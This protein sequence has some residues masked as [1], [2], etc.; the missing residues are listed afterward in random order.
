MRG[1]FAKDSATPGARAAK[2]AT[3][4]HTVG[5][6]WRADRPAERYRLDPDLDEGVDELALADPALTAPQSVS[7]QSLSAQTLPSGEPSLS[8]ADICEPTRAAWRAEIADIGGRSPLLHFEDSPYTRID[9]TSTHPGGLAKFIAGRRTRLSS[10]IREPFA[11]RTAA[12]AADAISA[13]GVELA[14]A[15]GIDSVKLGI[16]LAEWSVEGERFRAPVLLRPVRL[17]R[18]GSDFEIALRGRSVLNRAFADELATRF[19]VVLDPEAFAALASADGAFTPNAIIDR[20]RGLTSHLEDFTVTPRLLVS[21]FADVARPML[22]DARTLAHPVLDALAGN[23]AAVETVRES[24]PTVE[25]VPAD[26]RAP[27]IDRLVLDADAEQDQV[28]ARIAAGAS[29]V[30]KTL[31]GTGGTQTIVN[32]I[33]ALVADD[34][35]VLVVGARN[36][37]L[38]AIRE[39]LAAIGLA[40]LAASPGTASRDSIA[41]ITRNERAARVELDEIDSALVRLRSVLRDYRDALTRVD[42]VIGITVLD[43]VAELSA[44]ALRRPQAATT[45]RLSRAAVEASADPDERRRLAGIMVAAARFGE[46]RFGPGESPW[47]GAQFSSGDAAMRAHGL[48]VRLHEHALP[49]LLSRAD[50]IVEATR[51]RPITTVGDL[52]GIVRLLLDLRETLDRF[53]PSVFDRSLT[54]LIA[55]TAPKREHPDMHG[56]DRRRLRKL[57]EEHVRPGT[58]VTDLHDWLVRIQRQRVLWH[59]YVAEGAT[60]RV[61]VGLGETQITLQ[62]VLQDLAELDGP[63][64]RDEPGRRFSEMPIAQL[65]STLAGLAAESDALQNLQERS[66]LMGELHRMGLD[67][68]IADLGARKVREGLIADELE[69]AWWTSALASL[70]ES[71]RALL[72]ANTEV[73]D[74]LESDFRLVDEAHAAGNAPTLAWRIAQRWSMGIIDWPDEAEAL[75]RAL[76][77]PSVSTRDLYTA[78]P[79]LT[80]SLSPVWM[81]SPYDVHRIVETMPFDCVILVDAGATTLAENAAAIRRGRQVVAFGDPVTQTPTPFE[82]AIHERDTPVPLTQQEVEERHDGSALAVLATLLPTASLTRS[83]RTGGEDLADLVNRRFYGGRIQSLPWAGS[84]LGHTTLHV[85]Q[86]SARPDDTVESPESELQRVVDLVLDHASR[87]PTESL[88]VLTASRRHASRVMAAVLQAFGS[89]PDLVDFVTGERP[90]P[91]DVLTLEQAGAITR[92]RVLFSPGFGPDWDGQV[93]DLGPLGHPGGDRLLAV[94]MTSA[95]RGLTIV[96][97]LDLATVDQDAVPIGVAALAGVVGDVLAGRA[98]SDRPDD[99]DPMIVD[100]ARRLRERGVNARLG[101]R[102]DLALVA[103]YGGRCAVIDTD[104][105]LG[106]ASLRESLRLRPELL[107]RLG[108]HYVRVHAFELF[109]DPELVADR[110]GELLGAPPKPEPTDVDEVAA[111]EI[112]DALADAVE[113]AQAAED[114]MGDSAEEIGIDAVAVVAAVDTDPR[115]TSAIVDLPTEPI[116]LT[117]LDVVAA[118]ETV[119]VVAVVE[120][121]D[122]EVVEVVETVETPAVEEQPDERA[123][124]AGAADDDDDLSLDTAQPAL[125]DLPTQPIDIDD[126]ALEP[127]APVAGQDPVAAPAPRRRFGFPRRASSRP[128]GPAP[129]APVDAITE[130]IAIVAAADVPMELDLGLDRPDPDAGREYT[131]PRWRDDEDDLR[132]P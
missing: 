50:G 121:I 95:R 63:L 31:P 13:K 26:E 117:G 101:Y 47:F 46:F 28:V 55:A 27:Q 38:R 78:A 91:F 120:T 30:V 61:P 44:I 110:I 102:G 72:G 42:P 32:T 56:S 123:D 2:R 59:R 6:V 75:K 10:L 12:V 54:E 43:C 11:W 83:Y 84:F 7:A 106:A 126:L 79:H 68:L 8:L 41:A 19:G 113:A 24:N 33:G 60:P 86:V 129:T 17:R 80:K 87:R 58:R 74:R 37:S 69:L 94:A 36:A 66:A 124:P 115:R 1:E 107:R 4:R 93:G 81:T 112:E 22:A 40:G 111:A 104:I 109:Q 131:A 29:I 23:D 98:P 132:G 39:R 5:R 15:R 18:A 71:D 118:A 35:R 25:S 96:T 114:A 125:V 52:V 100:L 128:T 89:R 85:D 57:A 65:Q 14:T 53:Q 103:A 9:L 127:Q 48:A 51:M 62:A 90:E 16:V 130:P 119:E 20:L 82:V 73:L 76:R 88:M 49:T 67:P 21:S 77:R 116:D 45:A 3:R 34:K 122:I 92:D 99:G 64:G 70:L 97:V 108:W 105:D